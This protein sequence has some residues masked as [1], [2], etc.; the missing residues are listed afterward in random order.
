MIRWV[1]AFIDRPVSRLGA[2]ADFWAAVTGASPQPDAA[3]ARLHRPGADDWVEVHGV[4]DGPGGGHL[5]LSVDDV[6][7]FT[8]AA[9]S[10]GGVRVADHGDRQLLH[11]PAGLPFQVAAWRGQHLPP[12]PYVG[13]GGERSLLDQVCLDIGPAAYDAEVAYWTALTGWRLQRETSVEFRRLVPPPAVPV[14]LLLQR[15]ETDGPVAA[16]VDL[17][18]TDVAAVRADHERRGASVVDVRP[19]WTVMRDPAGG[20]YCL[21]S[22]PPAGVSA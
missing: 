4:S 14:Q 19:W 10:A 5:L 16:H 11:S 22:R 1:H 8:A 20:R 7:A 9:L 2:A 17:A 13:A 12:A 3:F 21:T 18:C 15:L 6:A